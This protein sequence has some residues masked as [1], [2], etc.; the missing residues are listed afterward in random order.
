MGADMRCYYDRQSADAIYWGDGKENGVCDCA[1]PKV[2]GSDGACHELTCVAT[3]NG[4]GCRTCADP[5][6]RNNECASCHDGYVLHEGDCLEN[7]CTE[8][9]DNWEWQG[10]QECRPK[11]SRRHPQDCL[12]CAHGYTFLYEQRHDMNQTDETVYSSG[13]LTVSGEE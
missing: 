5:L 13:S 7:I 4:A 6:T 10:C 11:E 1:F 9:P 12:S 8:D 3:E 2:L